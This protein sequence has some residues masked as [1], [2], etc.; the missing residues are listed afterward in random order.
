[1]EVRILTKVI[2]RNAE[3]STFGDC[4]DNW[5]RRYVA[6]KRKQAA[7]NMFK[8]PDSKATVKSKPPRQSAVEAMG[9][10]SLSPHSL[11]GGVDADAMVEPAWVQEEVSGFVT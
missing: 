4:L 2:T 3:E 9:S 10:N 1:M 7:G 11:V 6:G 8:M 5:N